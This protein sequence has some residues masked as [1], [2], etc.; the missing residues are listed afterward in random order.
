MQTAGTIQWTLNGAVIDSAAGNQTSTG[1]LELHLVTYETEENHY[2]CLHHNPSESTVYMQDFQ[3]AV[4]RKLI[5]IL[6]F[7]SLHSTDSVY[8]FVVEPPEAV[9]SI[10]VVTVNQDGREGT[11][12]I[13][14]E[15]G[16]MSDSI[17]TVMSYVVKVTSVE[18][19]EIIR[20]IEVSAEVNSTVIDRLDVN[21][22]YYLHI[23]TI[24]PQLVYPSKHIHFRVQ[25][26]S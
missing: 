17:D 19:N 1:Q 11:I 18:S 7:L 24:T 15:Y 10:Q 12:R 26:N 8:L 9:S 22:S 6:V 13:S 14:W 25:A 23:E 20:S 3:L 16:N 21:G 2:V 5:F 4:K